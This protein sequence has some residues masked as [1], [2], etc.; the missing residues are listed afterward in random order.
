MAGFELE[1][2]EGER[3]V[4]EM[5]VVVGK[6]YKK[7]PMFSDA[8]K[9]VEFNPYWNVPTSIVE[10]TL[11]SRFAKNST[12]AAAEG[13]EVL[14][15]DGALPVSAINWNQFA[16]KSVPFSVRQRP[17]KD[18]A[19]GQ[20]KFMFPNKYNVYLHDTNSKALFDK[21]VRTF[22]SGCVRLQKP[23]QLANYLQ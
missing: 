3:T 11:K 20:M 17:G 5:R 9:Y 10:D 1:V 2:I 15:G 19:L 16:S 4:L 6:N 22:S 8:I 18:N 13:F 23:H 12:Q 14:Q 7:T 21:T